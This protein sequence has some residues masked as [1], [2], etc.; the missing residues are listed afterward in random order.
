MDLKAVAAKQRSEEAFH[1][2]G[3]SPGAGQSLEEKETERAYQPAVQD[4][5]LSEL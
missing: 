5:E 1:E 3:R 4:V 2:H